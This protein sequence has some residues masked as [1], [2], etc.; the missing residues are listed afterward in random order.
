M[1]LFH[2]AILSIADTSISSLPTYTIF[3]P[4]ADASSRTTLPL[5]LPSDTPS[6]L[7]IPAHEL[8]S[9]SLPVKDSHFHPSSKDCAQPCADVE[10]GGGVE[11][12]LSPWTSPLPSSSAASPHKT[13]VTQTPGMCD[14]RTP[15]VCD[16]QTTGVCDTWTPGAGIKIKI[17]AKKVREVA[18]PLLSPGPVQDQGSRSISCSASLTPREDTP[19][20]LSPLVTS[21]PPSS[22][23]P[24]S[25]SLLPSSFPPAPLEDTHPKMSAFFNKG[26]YS[27][28]YKFNFNCQSGKFSHVCSYMCCIV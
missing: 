8:E 24:L 7:T 10:G 9:G 22:L 19:R 18:S 28:T 26:M 13:A 15:G 1:L 25:S 16:T 27:Y 11:E 17:S 20:A 23:A 3:S 2:L 5:S 21:L 4:L 6:P 14:T 12:G